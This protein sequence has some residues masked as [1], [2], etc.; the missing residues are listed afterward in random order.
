MIKVFE[1]IVKVSDEERTLTK[2]SLVYPEDELVPITICRDDDV[3]SHY[4]KESIEEFKGTP[5]DVRVTIKMD[6]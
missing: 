6:W 3:L 1:L 2:K 4:V 5:S